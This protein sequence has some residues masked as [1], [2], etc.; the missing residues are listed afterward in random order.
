MRLFLLYN[1]FVIIDQP[2][3]TINRNKRKKIRAYTG[4]NLDIGYLDGLELLE[5]IKADGFI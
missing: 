3:T 2:A 4:C 5:F 1:H